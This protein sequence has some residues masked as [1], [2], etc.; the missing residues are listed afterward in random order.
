MVHTSSFHRLTTPAPDCDLRD[1][2][3]APPRAPIG[4]AFSISAAVRATFFD[5]NSIHPSE[6]CDARFF[7]PVAPA[8][9]GC[10]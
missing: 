8:S 6:K 10:K 2:C 9:L 7:L 4:C 3:E 5:R 1:E